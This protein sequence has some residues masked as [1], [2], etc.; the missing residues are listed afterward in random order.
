MVAMSKAD[1]T[2][3]PSDA[4]DTHTCAYPC[5]CARMHMRTRRMLLKQILPYLYVLVTTEEDKRN[6]CPRTTQCT[7]QRGSAGRGFSLDKSLGKM[8]T[9]KKKELN[10]SQ[11]NRIVLGSIN[12]HVTTFARVRLWTPQVFGLCK[13][14]LWAKFWDRSCSG[15]G[16]Y[17]LLLQDLG[18][19][20]LVVADL[21]SYQ[22]WIQQTFGSS[23]L[24][25]L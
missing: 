10:S 1:L 15:R 2:C 16:G 20:L 12:Q 14:T 18:C 13:R 11:V 19:S 4:G 9:K 5:A 21:W 23:L 17:S 22:G 25:S 3:V 8:R 7:Q 24:L 6:F